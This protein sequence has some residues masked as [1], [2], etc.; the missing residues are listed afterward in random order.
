M[1]RNVVTDLI[2]F[3]HVKVTK[4]VAVDVIKEA[5]RL[6]TL[7]KSSDVMNAKRRAAAFVRNVKLS[8]D[9]DVTALD[10]LFAVIGPKFATREGGYTTQVK[11]GNRRGDDAPIVLVAWVE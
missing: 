11:L 3:G 8:N 2:R 7:T 6:V 1:L 5:D 9:S 4:A 10:H